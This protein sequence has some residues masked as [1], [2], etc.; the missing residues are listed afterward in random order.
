MGALL[1]SPALAPSRGYPSQQGCEKRRVPQC[2]L[3]GVSSL[4]LKIAGTAGSTNPS[5]FHIRIRFSL[6]LSLHAGT[7]HASLN[8][9]RARSTEI[10]LDCPNQ[11]ICQW[12]TCRTLHSYYL[13]VGIRVVSWP[14][15]PPLIRAH[16]RPRIES[17]ATKAALMPLAFSWKQ[18]QW[19]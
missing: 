17:T 15:E 6:S 5:S 9:K 10:V 8:R 7:H 14:T 3:V 18:Y 13:R 2:I 11:R 12:S 19:E 16:E 4:W 1:E